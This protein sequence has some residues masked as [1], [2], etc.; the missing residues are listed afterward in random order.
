[1]TLDGPTAF[2]FEIEAGRHR[3]TLRVKAGYVHGVPAGSDEPGE[4]AH[5][6]EDGEAWDPGLCA[7]E[8]YRLTKTE[9]VRRRW[10]YQHLQELFPDALVE[11]CEE[12]L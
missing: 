5:L 3:A 4:P 7:Y 12:Q 10:M 1:M 2:D 11:A 9:I 6:S 8:G